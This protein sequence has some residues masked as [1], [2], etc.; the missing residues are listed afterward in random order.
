MKRSSATMLTAMRGLP[1][2]TYQAPVEALRCLDMT[3]G[4]IRVP[5]FSKSIPTS[6]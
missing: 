4:G 3:S 6:L 5:V 2:T 1:E